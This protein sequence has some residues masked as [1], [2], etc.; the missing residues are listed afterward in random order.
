MIFYKPGQAPPQPI[1]TIPRVTPPD[2]FLFPS[3]VKSGDPMGNGR[4]FE[5]SP[6]ANTD[7][8]ITHGLGRIP[9]GVWVMGDFFTGAGPPGSSFYSPKWKRS[10]VTAWTVA[11]ITIQLDTTCTNCWIWIN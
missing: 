9:S 5:I 11:A 7:I 4:V 3:V 1:A 8:T 2:P 6:T 10:T